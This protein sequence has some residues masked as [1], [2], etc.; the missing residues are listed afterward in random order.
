MSLQERCYS[1][2]GRRLVD[3]SSER[4]FFA[5]RRRRTEPR[6]GFV[7]RR[8]GGGGASAS[9][10]RVAMRSRASVRLRTCERCVDALTV[11][12]VPSKRCSRLRKMRRRWASESDAHAAM[13]M[14]SCTL[15]SVVLTPWPPGTDAFANRSV[16][17]AAAT[18]RPPGI[19]G[20]GAMGQVLHAQ[21]PTFTLGPKTRQ[22][23]KG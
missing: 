7:F 18:T 3:F 14:E 17:S 11:R 15:L 21:H 1:S 2:W 4:R 5:S 23:G 6:V 16:R 19:P 10:N 13:S 8:R 20:P 22:L 9:R 12:T